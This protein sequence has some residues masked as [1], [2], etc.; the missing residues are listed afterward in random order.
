MGFHGLCENRNQFELL[1]VTAWFIERIGLQIFRKFL[2]FRKF[3]RKL[4][5]FQE[6]LPFIKNMKVTFTG[7]TQPFWEKFTIVLVTCISEKLMKHLNKRIHSQRTSLL[8]ESF[9]IHSWQVWSPV[10]D[11][12]S[13]IW[14]CLSFQS[15]FEDN[16]DDDKY[17]GH[18]YGLGSAYVQNGTAFSEENNATT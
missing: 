15:Y 1:H 11:L 4:G 7:I 13:L 3:C 9:K 12:K 14:L 2:D 16:I 10:I 18:L 17:C 8:Q 6:I 5:I